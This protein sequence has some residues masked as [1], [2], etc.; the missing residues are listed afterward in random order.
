M[1]II[2]LTNVRAIVEADGKVRCINCIDG[3]NYRLGCEPTEEVLV[4]DSD[5]ENPDKLFICDYCEKQL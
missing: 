3:E 1:P 4:S 5:I 2:D